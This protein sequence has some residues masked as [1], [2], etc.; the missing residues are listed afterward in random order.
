MVEKKEQ[1]HCFG[2]IGLIKGK[3]FFEEKKL[4]DIA[5]RVLE[6]SMNIQRK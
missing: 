2:A 3:L 5:N 4:A 6:K 1:K